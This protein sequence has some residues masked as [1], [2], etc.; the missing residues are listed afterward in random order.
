MFSNITKIDAEQYPSGIYT[1]IISTKNGL[2]T[3]KLTVTK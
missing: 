3:K 2:I 1:L